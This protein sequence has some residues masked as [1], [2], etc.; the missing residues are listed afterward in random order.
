MI[1]QI[2]EINYVPCIGNFKSRNTK[3]DMIAKR[4]FGN[5]WTRLFSTRRNDGLPIMK[6]KFVRKVWYDYMGFTQQQI[7][8]YLKIDRTTVNHHIHND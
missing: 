6:K 2:F 4:M 5:E 8:D 1:K 7:A 3:L